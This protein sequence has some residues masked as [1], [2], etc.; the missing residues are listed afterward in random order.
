MVMTIVVV[1]VVEKT[2]MIEQMLFGYHIDDSV[3][4]MAMMMMMMIVAT[5]KKIVNIEMVMYIHGEVMMAVSLILVTAVMLEMVGV[6][7]T[8]IDFAS[9]AELPRLRTRPTFFGVTKTV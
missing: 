5:I 1:F 7:T 3:I 6:N 4:L 8:R 9:V 2:V